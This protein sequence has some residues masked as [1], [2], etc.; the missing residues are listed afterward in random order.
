MSP[1]GHWSFAD[2]NLGSVSAPGSSTSFQCSKIL[3]LPGFSAHLKLKNK[4]R[5]SEQRAMFCGTWLVAV[6][7]AVR[8]GGVGGPLLGP[9]RICKRPPPAAPPVTSWSH[10]AA[11]G[12]LG[13]TRPVLLRSV[14][15]PFL[16]YLPVVAGARRVWRS[17][18]RGAGASAEPLPLQTAATPLQG[19]RGKDARPQDRPAELTAERHSVY[20]EG[21]MNSSAKGGKQ[22]LS[23]PAEGG[24]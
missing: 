15:S 9:Q 2:G 11:R 20:V 21:S 7:A 22:V 1:R 17:R 16:A 8:C 6:G 24:M 23:K 19:F 4:G 18:Y 5:E 13:R 12:A 10:R 14:R 3:N